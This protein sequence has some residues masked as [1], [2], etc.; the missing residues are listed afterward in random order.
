MKE[1]VARKSIMLALMTLCLFPSPGRSEESSEG[2]A[3]SSEKATE[4]SSPESTPST[5]TTSENSSATSSAPTTEQTT[6][7]DRSAYIKGGVRA[8]ALRTLDGLV[9]IESAANFLQGSATEVMKEVTRKETVVVRGPNYIGNGIVIPAIG[10]PSGT[11]QMGKLPARRKKLESFLASCEE[12]FAALES[13]V[14]ALIVGPEAPQDIQNLWTGM[15]ATVAATKESITQM[16]DLINQKKLADNQIGKA[17]LKV[18]D[19]MTALNKIR[20][21]ML[22]RVKTE[23]LNQK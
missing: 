20:E 16:H 14:H 21:Q 9:S 1:H 18:Y 15:R 23:E 3:S 6:T 10:G 4:I 5:S 22:E 7:E 19:S 8:A 17:A 2:K 13:Q 12:S 11:M